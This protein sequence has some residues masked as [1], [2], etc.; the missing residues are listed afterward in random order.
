MQVIGS[1][2]DAQGASVFL[3]GPSGVLQARV[4]DVLLTE[5]RVAE[6]TPQQVHLKHLLTNQVVSLTVPQDARQ[7]LTAATA[8]N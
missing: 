1:W 8:P 3:A 7:S 5:F 6:I 4:G 2:R